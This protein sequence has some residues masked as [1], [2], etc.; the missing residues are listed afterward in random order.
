MAAKAS[1][2]ARA[3]EGSAFRVLDPIDGALVHRRVGRSVPEGLEIDVTGAAPAGAQVLIQGKPASRDGEQFRGTALLRQRETTIPVICQAGGGPAQESSIRVIWNMN[4][5]KRY[6]FVI[7][8]NS[9][10]LRDVAQKGYRSLFDCFYLKMLRDLNKKYGASF[11]LNIY[12]AT[13]DG[14]NLTQFPDKYRAEW[15]DNAHWLRLAFH[16]YANEPSWPYREAPLEKL[17][18]DVDLI[19]GE[20]HRFAPDAFSPVA[21]VHWGSTRADAWKS[22][23]DRGTRVLGGYFTKSRGQWMVHYGMDDFRCQ[24]LSHHDLLKDYDSGMIFSKVD[25]V[26]NSTPLDQ[27][28]PKLEPVLADPCQGEVIDFLTHEQYFW[29][30]Y[31]RYLPDCAERMDR[32]IGF[33]AQHGH[34]PVFLQDGFLG[35]PA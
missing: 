30:F 10:F 25:M 3:A 34:K 19:N 23:Y 12:Y 16:A 14:W 21:V 22:L 31:K 18:A 4:S 28:V 35:G 15:K 29:P 11:T 1:A 24:W 33:V 27:I 26:V 13:E 6:R 8:D 2:S 32:A 7:D 20:I 9:F 5:Q 17:L